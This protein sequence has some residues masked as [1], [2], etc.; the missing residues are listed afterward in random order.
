MM[1]CS[2]CILSLAFIPG[3]RKISRLNERL[4]RDEKYIPPTVSATPE[5]MAQRKVLD[6]NRWSVN[7]SQCTAKPA[8][9]TMHV[10]KDRHFPF[11]IKIWALKTGGF[12]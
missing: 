8:V 12:W 3:Q 4:R 10:W 5:T 2:V 7:L 9:R 6:L 1:Y 11:A